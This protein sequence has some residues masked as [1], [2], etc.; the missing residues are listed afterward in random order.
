MTVTPELRIDWFRIL[1]DLCQD[2]GSLYQVSRI[3]SIPRS[4]LQNYKQG[5]EPSHSLGMCL[6][7]LWAIKT[8]KDRDEAP[9][10]QRYDPIM[11]R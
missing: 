3:T 2:G 9:T 1:T 5:V 10:Q 11:V 6:L 7:R 4:T 8:G